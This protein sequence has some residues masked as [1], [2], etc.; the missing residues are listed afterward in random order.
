MYLHFAG[1][2]HLLY[3]LLLGYQHKTCLS[4]IPLIMGFLGGTVV[5]NLPA[6]AGDS[7]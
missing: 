5:K 2:A 6:D 7:G 4:I 3:S 1:G